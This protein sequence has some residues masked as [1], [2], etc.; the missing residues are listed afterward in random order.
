MFR[1][2]ALAAVACSLPITAQGPTRRAVPDK[3]SIRLDLA[4]HEPTLIVVKFAE[5]SSAHLRRGRLVTKVP[6]GAL[7]RALGERQITAFFD[8]LD[9]Q[10]DALDRRIRAAAPKADLTP[11]LR[12]YHLVQTSGPADS[13]AL[14]RALNAL[15]IVELA[16]PKELP[17]PPPG[18][19]PPTTPSFVARQ[20]YRAAAPA[21]INAFAIRQLSGASGSNLQILDVEWSWRFKHEDIQRLRRSSLVG[22]RENVNFA[23]HGTA[24]IGEL[25]GDPDAWGVTGLVPDVRVLCASAFPQGKSYSVARAIVTG[26]TRLQ[27]GD[28]LLLEAQTRTPLGLGPTEYVQADF[29]AIVKATK[30]GVIT[31]EAAGNGGVNLDAAQLG[32]RFDLSKRDSGAIIVGATEGVATRRA[33]FSCYGSRIDA[34]GWGRNVTSTGYGDLFNPNGDARQRYTARFSGTSSASPIVTSAVLALLSGAKAQRSQQAFGAFVDHTKIRALLRAHGTPVARIARRPNCAKLLR[35]AGLVHGLELLNQPRVGQTFRVQVEADWPTK[36]GDA[37]LLLA[38][39]RPANVGLP[40]LQ[41]PC[42]RLLLDSST[43]FVVGTGG[44]ASGTKQSF[45]ITVANDR[46]LRFASFY[47]QALTFRGRDRRLCLTNAAMSWIE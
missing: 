21:G 20:G 14:L 23:N 7:R 26:L 11:D 43:M 45:P 44:F 15:D 25:A 36:A 30:A 32:G 27:K 18:D 1:S 35:A 28:V 39:P 19:V 3:Q 38:S 33:S 4:R 37:W 31:V 5:G 12:L 22:P 2:F 42:N 16:Y 6:N 29:D 34:N 17:T 24:V 9:Q 40:F 13:R 47:W 41:A 46:S 10:L 8:G